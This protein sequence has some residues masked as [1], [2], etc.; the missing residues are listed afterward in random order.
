MSSNKEKRSQV[1]IPGIRRQN[2]T[3]TVQKPV[4]AKDDVL[5]GSDEDDSDWEDE[6]TLL[7]IED[8]WTDDEA[9][10]SGDDLQTAMEGIEK[11]AIVKE[12]RS[13]RKT[14]RFAE[15]TKHFPPSFGGSAGTNNVFTVGR[16][17]DMG[18]STED[19]T[20]LNA[21]AKIMQQDRT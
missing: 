10:L 7:T 20:I 2:K 17:V 21:Y 3:T 8:Y 16:E 6:A 19:L 4:S 13:K 12:P 14:V 15:E 18:H 9:P 5:S 11:A 1:A